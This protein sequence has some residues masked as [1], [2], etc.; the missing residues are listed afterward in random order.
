[1]EILSIL[2]PNMFEAVTLAWLIGVFYHT[3]LFNF[4]HYNEMKTYTNILHIYLWPIT[5]VLYYIHVAF[6]KV[7]GYTPADYFE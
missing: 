7:Q 6:C 3:E 4:T 5:R 2:A 1:M